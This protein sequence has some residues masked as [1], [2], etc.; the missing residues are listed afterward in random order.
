[1]GSQAA[2]LVDQIN[3]DLTYSVCFNL[4]N[5]YHANKQYTEALAILEAKRPRKRAGG[6][7]NGAALSK[8]GPI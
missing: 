5:Q 1:M 6:G 7:A 2:G 8:A 4:A 3:I